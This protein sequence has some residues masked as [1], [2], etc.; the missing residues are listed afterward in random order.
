MKKDVFL[1]ITLGLGIGMLVASY[2]THRSIVEEKR[3]RMQDPRLAQVEA[4]LDEAENLL[5][6]VGK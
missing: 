4:L 5:K 1:W 6:S 2:F 3:K